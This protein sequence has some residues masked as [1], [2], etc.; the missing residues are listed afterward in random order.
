MISMKKFNL[1]TTKKWTSTPK[2]VVYQEPPLTDDDAAVADLLYCLIVHHRIPL[3]LDK[4][5]RTL[6][7]TKFAKPLDKL[8]AMYQST[9]GYMVED[10]LEVLLPAML[11][12]A[13]AEQRKNNKNF[14]PVKGGDIYDLAGI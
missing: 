1:M 2:T 3:D 7:A 14:V 9:K 5:L 11:E 10:V 13:I 6:D 8:V 12:E 4:K